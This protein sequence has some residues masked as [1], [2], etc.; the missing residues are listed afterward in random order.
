L[1]QWPVGTGTLTITVPVRD[2]TLE[3]Y[4]IKFFKRFSYKGF[5]SLEFKKHEG[6]GKYYI[7]EP[8]VGRPDQQLYVATANGINMPLA[9]Y[10]SLTGK[11]L[12]TTPFRG[13]IP[14]KYVENWFDLFSGAQLIRKSQIGFNEFFKSRQGPKVY[15]FLDFRD[16]GVF[17]YTY[18][19]LVRKIFKRLKSNFL[20]EH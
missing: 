2:V 15:S 1:R 16:L 17:L 18:V 4:T 9:A 3:N 5:G 7:I 20:D 13:G 14:V 19:F 12:A 10:K 11:F 6:N 8:T